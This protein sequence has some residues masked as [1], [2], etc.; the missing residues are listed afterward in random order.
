VADDAV[1]KFRERNV[2]GIEDEHEVL[3]CLRERTID[4]AGLRA[5]DIE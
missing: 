5:R 2:I 1:E 4:L 3:A